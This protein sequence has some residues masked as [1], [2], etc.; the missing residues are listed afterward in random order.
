VP[1][2]YAGAGDWIADAGGAFIFAAV[3]AWRRGRR[4]RGSNRKGDSAA[5]PAAA[6]TPR[7]SRPEP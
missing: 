3:I 1:G 7:R 6:A 4:P 2:R 5:G